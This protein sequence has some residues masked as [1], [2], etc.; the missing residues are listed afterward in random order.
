MSRQKQRFRGVDGHRL[1]RGLQACASVK[2]KL[3]FRSVFRDCVLGYAFQGLNVAFMRISISAVILAAAVASMVRTPSF[4]E[5]ATPAPSAPE[6]V[7]KLKPNDI[8]SIL[9][10]AGYNCESANA[11]AGKNS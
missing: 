6:V 3:Q 5:S 2:S 4:A 10:D 7:V 9:R 8:A 11:T 1:G